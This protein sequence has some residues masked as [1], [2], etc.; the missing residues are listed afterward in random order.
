MTGTGQAFGKLDKNIENGM[1]VDKAVDEI[2]RGLTLGYTEQMMGPA[3]VQ[4]LPFMQVC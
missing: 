2:L 3:I 4:A 1:P